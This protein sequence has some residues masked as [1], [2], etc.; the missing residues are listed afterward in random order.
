M[1]TD[2]E[3]IRESRPGYDSN[4]SA[5]VSEVEYKFGWDLS[6]NK[7]RRIV[8]LRVNEGDL[9][10]GGRGRRLSYESKLLYTG[11]DRIPGELTK[12]V[13]LDVVE[14]LRQ[15]GDFFRS[16]YSR[17]PAIVEETVTLDLVDVALR[18]PDP[19]HERQ[20]S[21]SARRNARVDGGRRGGDREASRRD[22][23]DR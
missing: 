23:E 6:R 1:L 14:I 18:R 7:F 9:F 20:P 8:V 17:P 5:V 12:S 4:L 3:R 2:K 16:R 21:R 13:G 22:R 10:S 11:S 19:D 15:R